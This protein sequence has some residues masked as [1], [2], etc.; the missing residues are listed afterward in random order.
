[1]LHKY[2]FRV[3]AIL[4]LIS[5]G[6][7]GCKD[8][9]TPKELNSDD[10]ILVINGSITNT[11]GPHKVNL[12]YATAFLD[13]SRQY[14]NNAK[15]WVVDG[16][17]QSYDFTNQGDGNYFTTTNQLVGE[18]GQSYTLM[19]ELLNGNQYQST[20]TIM[21]EPQN[22]SDIYAEVGK[23]GYL[24]EQYDGS[25]LEIVKEGLFV[26]IDLDLPISEKKYFRFD[27]LLTSQSTFTFDTIDTVTQRQVTKTIYCIDATGINP[28]PD[29]STTTKSED[30]QVAP[31][32]QLT[33][34][35]YALKTK[36]WGDYVLN[37]DGTYTPPPSYTAYPYGW[38][39]TTTMY[40]ISRE[41]YIYYDK[42]KTQ[43]SST[44]Q[45]FDPIPS[46]IKG[47]IKSL[48]DSTETVLGLFS[49]ASRTIASEGIFWTPSSST[50]LYQTPIDYPYTS[51]TSFMVSD[52][53][54]SGWVFFNNSNSN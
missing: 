50:I 16:N 35:T 9:Y 21:A 18:V 8:I 46:S 49:V 26:Y 42:V 54:P 7:T 41:E 48:N 22:Y 30:K 11:A 32:H 36:T 5:L 1:M 10:K 23:K 34:I 53:A 43:L 40:S 31:R 15:V 12:C 47:N 29:I 38:V 19:V 25:Y 6:W 52:N 33:F 39:V 24:E 27:R 20:T 17:G 44:D 28:L 4:S 45:I 14:I 2:I 13:N 37:D 51:A 3:I